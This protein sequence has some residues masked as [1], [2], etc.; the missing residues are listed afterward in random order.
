MS[1]ERRIKKLE[2][3]ETSKELK[4]LVVIHEK[5]DL[6]EEFQFDNVKDKPKTYSRQKLKELEEENYHLI[7]LAKQ[8]LTPYQSIKNK[9]R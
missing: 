4:M 9:S 8:G 7:I 6:F 1:L 3:L 5:E 2:E